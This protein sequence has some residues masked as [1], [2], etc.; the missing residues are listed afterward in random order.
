M[1]MV[2]IFETILWKRK[3]IKWDWDEEEK[4]LTGSVSRLIVGR[5]VEQNKCPMIL[6][7]RNHSN[8]ILSIKTNAFEQSLHRVEMWF[9]WIVD[10]DI[11]LDI[12]EDFLQTDGFDVVFHISYR[13]T[14]ERILIEDVAFDQQKRFHRISRSKQLSIL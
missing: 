5:L 11:E 12:F 13:S 14:N 6:L 2:I 1:W 4:S 10:K 7:I 8:V 9:V 3:S